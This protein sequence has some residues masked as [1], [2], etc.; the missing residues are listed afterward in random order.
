MIRCS[1]RSGTA[2]SD[3]YP[4]RVMTVRTR[5]RHVLPLVQDV[6][7]LDRRPGGRGLPH[8]ALSEPDRR[9]THH[10]GELVF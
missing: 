5:A 1:R 3:R 9:G 7:H 4:S 2:R 10:R 8:G 6:R